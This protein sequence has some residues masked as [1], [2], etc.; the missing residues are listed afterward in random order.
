M[1]KTEAG[2]RHPQAVETGPGSLPASRS[3]LGKTLSCRYTAETLADE[4]CHT[5]TA[6][7][8]HRSTHTA[9]EHT[10]RHIRT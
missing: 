9:E 7:P 8:R 10:Q 4:S 6:M 1:H 3:G 5:D 2:E